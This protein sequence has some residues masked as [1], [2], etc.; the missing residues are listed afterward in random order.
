M[1]T[2]TPA[3]TSRRVVLADAAAPGGHVGAWR[4]VA[5]L[6]AMAGSLGLLLVAFGWMGRWEGLLLA[7][8]LAS[9]AA[10]FTRAGERF[11]VAVGFGFRRPSS[12]QRAALHPP[13]DSALDRAG[14]ARDTVDLYVAPGGDVNAYAVGRRSIAVTKGTLQAYRARRLGG[15]EL[16]AVLL[17]EF[18]HRATRGAPFALV[19]TWLALPWRLMSRAV[20]ILGLATLGRRQPIRL[21]GVVVGAVVVRAVVQAIEQGQA[22][23]AVLLSTLAF[24]AV[25]CS[26]AD[27]RISRRSEYAADRFAT[28]HGAGLQLAAALARLDRRRDRRQSWTQAGLNRHPNTERRIG[29]I[30]RLHAR[31]RQL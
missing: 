20:L 19:A 14:I 11:A 5:S 9:G 24:N 22:A 28:Q 1:M 26:L 12:A 21:L 17:H 10:V 7:G 2:M 29:A 3:S 16:E 6:P 15:V 23:V 25:A 8:W 4:A 27:A 18:G 31:S 13:W 30:D